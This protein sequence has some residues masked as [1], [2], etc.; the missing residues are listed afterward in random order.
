MDTKLARKQLDSID[1]QT[2]VGRAL[3][4]TLEVLKRLA[5]RTASAKEAHTEIAAMAKK[6]GEWKDA[7]NK[8][9][10]KVTLYEALSATEQQSKAGHALADTLEQLGEMLEKSRPV[11]Y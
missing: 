7:V 3:Y 4:S 2:S 8:Y 1:E 5:D 9:H 11:G 6:Y 10:G